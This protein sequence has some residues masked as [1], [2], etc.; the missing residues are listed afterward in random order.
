MKIRATHFFLTIV[1]LLCFFFILPVCANAADD[2]RTVRVGY[3][4][5]PGFI[6]E[7][8]N[9]TYTGLGV[10]YLNEIAK[11]TGWNYVYIKGSRT[12]LAQKLQDGEIDFL[13]P[14]MKTSARDGTIYD[15]PTQSIGVAASGL[16][17]RSDSMQIYYDDYSHMQGIRVGGTPDSFQMTAAKEYAAQHGLTFTE[18]YYKNYTEVRNALDRGE[19]D[20]M[21]LSSLYKI[22]GYRLVATTR[23][24][25]FYIVAKNNHSH[26][27]LEQLDTALERIS[28]EHP[29]LF[30]TI[31]ERHYGRNRNAA[32]VSLTREEGNYIASHPVIT[33]G[34]FI[35]W[36]PLVY[37]NDKTGTEKGI[38]VDTLRLIESRSG[39]KFRFVPITG[40]SSI[41]AV[42]NRSSNIDLF[43]AV[44]STPERLRDPELVLSHG[45]M[46][47]KRAFAGLKSR[48]FNLHDNYTIAM[49]KEIKG[50]AAF[51]REH[52]PNFTIIEYPSLEECFHAVQRGEADA[53]F[54][55][56]YIISAMLQHPEFEDMT[57]WDVS[58][59]IG[60]NFYLAGRS[61][62]DPHLM[63]ILNKYIDSINPDDMQSI[64]FKNT[65]QSTTKLTLADITHKYSLTIELTLFLLFLIGLVIAKNIRDNRHHI[66]TL[67]ERNSQLSAAIT[68]AELAS[69]AKSDFLSR[70]SHEIRTPM[71]AIIGMTEIANKNLDDKNR[72]AASLMKITLASKILLNLIN[73]ILDMSAIEHKK[74][75]VA[76]LPFRLDDV[77]SPIA[78]IYAQQCHDKGLHFTYENK[79]SVPPLLG[80]SKRLTQIF[81][82]LLSNAVKFTEAG[83]MVTFTVTRLSTD[84]DR[85]FLRF[86]VSDTG[87]GMTE[88]FKKRIFQPFEQA[89]TTTFQKF[90]G[91]GLG[92]SIAH[93]LVNLMDGE[94]HVT[95]TPGQG[96]SFTVDLPFV[97][98]KEAVRTEQ[99]DKPAP[100]AAPPVYS[101]V[102]KRI[103]L[104]E[105]NMLNQEVASELLRMT[106]ATVVTAE[107]GKVAY[108]L[109]RKSDPGVFQAILMDI[110]MPVMDGY[111]A[112]RA[113]RA[114]SHP[115]AKTIPIIAM[116]ANAF[117]EDVTKSMAA[118]MNNHIAKPINTQEL[119]RLLDSYLNG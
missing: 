77:L 21:A 17:V 109:F 36:Y 72:I 15:Y 18:V 44:V 94:I 41:D 28:Y 29:T 119:F 67:N 20:A 103:L 60:G 100:T 66:A 115:Q 3:T 74:L 45:Y 76:A 6:D 84:K 37:F 87:I 26:D 102:G 23:L 65:S 69:Q 34:C 89:S 5:H 11:Y 106:G 48:P 93:N 38:L 9:G 13:A 50:S 64:I 42:K 24:A 99:A 35:D 8:D 2:A 81:F 31:F 83:G 114:C 71:N 46:E 47:N 108:D 62:N 22:D 78:G 12:E 55:N 56:S 101:F 88:D 49:P 63:A 70:M 104:V 91:S 110:Q 33:V 98:S 43:I 4:V 90:G 118:G 39:I 116:T 111:S 19:I 52:Y 54:Q 92:L 30:S 61:S 10:D 96:T 117:A 105:D 16:Y 112:S 113:I 68:Q 57:I 32:R 82:N 86:I 80:D 14:I 40:S 59:Q 73:D 97:T 7:E 85:Q 95:S 79:A 58:N 53:A 27:L 75:R 51:L 25:P 1:Y 107:D